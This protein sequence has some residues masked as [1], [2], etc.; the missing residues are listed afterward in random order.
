MKLDSKTLLAGAAA[1]V[2]LGGG[3]GMAMTGCSSS[4]DADADGGA[5]SSAGQPP[6][7][8]EGNATTDS[9]DRTFAV[10]TLKLG[11]NNDWRKLGY[12]IDGK[13]STGASKDV[14]KPAANALTSPH[15]DGDNG[16]DNSFGAIVLKSLIDIQPDIQNLANDALRDGSFT[17][18]IQVKGL[19]TA[20]PSALTGLSG[21]L[22]AGGN[23]D[24]ED[25][26]ALPAFDKTTDWPVL[27]AILKDESSVAS[28]SKITFA[29]SYVADGTFVSGDRL[30]VT[31]NLNFSGIQLAL[32]VKNAIITGK[33][34]GSDMNDGIISGYLV[35]S[36][37]EKALRD[38]G[39]R[40]SLSFCGS[41]VDTFVDN[42]KTSSDLL[43]D[44]TTDGARE[45]DAISIGLGFSAKEI[46][47]PTKI[48]KVAPGDTTDPC[49]GDGG[50]Q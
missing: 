28:G 30:T 41:A 21:Q 40:L 39:G 19:P 2:L 7:R 17:I 38:V 23:F 12:N 48:A 14:C 16:I 8:P 27:P 13:V 42:L 43:A 35:T 46:A 36:E 24:T 5:A 20:A 50:A 3:A 49:L 32:S 6:A 15:Q 31:L 45:C 11:L 33:P 9:T 22:F 26:G 34:S 37:V 1:L 10:N 29:N 47:N 44:G 18:M 4:D 25:A